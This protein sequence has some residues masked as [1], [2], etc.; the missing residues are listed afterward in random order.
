MSRYFLLRKISLCFSQQ[1]K[2]VCNSRAKFAESFHQ[3][4]NLSKGN[5]TFSL[6]MLVYEIQSFE[7]RVHS[8]NPAKSVVAAVVVSWRRTVWPAFLPSQGLLHLRTYFLPS[9]LSRSTS[10]VGFHGW[11][12]ARKE[13]IY[14]VW[15]QDVINNSDHQA[16]LRLSNLVEGIY[17][18]KLTVADGKGLKGNDD[19]ILTVKEGALPNQ[20][21]NAWWLTFYSA[22]SV[23]LFSILF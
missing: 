23:C 14:Y 10:Y 7:T 19:V 12:V 21:V 5:Q 6:N 20:F 8:L 22:T 4:S 9:S 13:S 18:F 3:M 2:C 1:F 15:L 16:V 11:N 17:K